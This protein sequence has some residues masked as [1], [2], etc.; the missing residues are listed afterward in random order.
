MQTG[1]SGLRWQHAQCI[2]GVEVATLLEEMALFRT[3]NDSIPR[4][5]YGTPK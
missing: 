2:M 4:F 5:I 3:R 1:G